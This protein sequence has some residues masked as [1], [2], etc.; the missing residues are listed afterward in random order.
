MGCNVKATKPRIFVNAPIFSDAEKPSKIPKIRPKPTDSGPLPPQILISALLRTRTPAQCPG[1]TKPVSSPPPR[2]MLAPS[3]SR[4]R[5]QVRPRSSCPARTQKT[6]P[7]T[8]EEDT[9]V[10]LSLVQPTKKR[11]KRAPRTNELTYFLLRCA[12]SANDRYSRVCPSVTGASPIG[13]RGHAGAL[14]PRRH[15][16]NDDRI[17]ARAPLTNGECDA[18]ADAP[19][20]VPSGGGWNDAVVPAHF[21]DLRKCLSS[22]KPDLGSTPTTHSRAHG[23]PVR[24]PLTRGPRTRRRW[25]PGGHDARLSTNLRCFSKEPSAEIRLS[26]RK[27]TN[28]AQIR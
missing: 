24:C 4:P 8:A 20:A 9:A 11:H 12:H 5:R 6:T 15:A 21:M 18:F 16:S 28:S 13:A 3:S 17:M 25:Q 23:S 19:H 22:C 1:R 10:A 2:P 14:P 7:V 26:P 27:N